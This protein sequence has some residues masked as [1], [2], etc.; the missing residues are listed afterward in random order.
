MSAFGIDICGVE[1]ADV[2]PLPEVGHRIVVGCDALDLPAEQRAGVEVILLL[3]VI[4]HIADPQFFLQ[5]IMG[6][7]PALHTVLV[8][9]PAR[10]ELWSNYDEYFGHF[11]RYDIEMLHQLGDGLGIDA[12]DCK[13]F[14]HLPYLPA[15]LMSVLGIKRG[16]RI[17]PPLSSMQ[18]ALHRYISVLMQ[19]A[20][21]CIPSRL[22]GS[23]ALAVYHINS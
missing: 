7:F 23:S 9:V 16:V 15:R 13:Y 6:C 3:D 5:G 10:M 17:L 20:N 18:I 12:H 8:T 19:L 21:R 2:E 1:L 11:R 14:F 4:E 22:K